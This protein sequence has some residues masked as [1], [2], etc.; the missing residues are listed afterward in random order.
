[1]F[2]IDAPEQTPLHLLEET[3]TSFLF[4]PSPKSAWKV[5]FSPTETGNNQPDIVGNFW[6]PCFSSRAARDDSIV[7][8]STVP[9]CP[10]GLKS[11]THR[12]SQQWPAPCPL[13]HH[14]GEPASQEGLWKAAGQKPNQLGQTC[15][16][17]HTD[18]LTRFL[19]IPFPDD[20]N[21]L[22]KR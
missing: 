18:G 13:G 21:R 1:M 22:E 3:V 2:K 15:N 20:R 8:N 11:Q 10:S 5:C 17:G 9:S 4:S 12:S 19:S 6:L 16:H 7:K 14:T